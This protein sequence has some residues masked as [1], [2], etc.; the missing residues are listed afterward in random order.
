MMKGAKP[1]TK[2]EYH[3]K[4]MLLKISRSKFQIDNLHIQKMIQC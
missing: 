3:F 2:A 1:T 4:T